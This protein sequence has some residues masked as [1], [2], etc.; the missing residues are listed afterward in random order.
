MPSGQKEVNTM[1]DKFLHF[2]KKNRASSVLWFCGGAAVAAKLYGLA[3]VL[4]V[5]GTV[6]YSIDRTIDS[7][8]QVAMFNSFEMMLNNMNKESAVT[9]EAVVVE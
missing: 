9:V 6:N 3:I 1:K 4:T 5:L 8:T 2:I 7:F